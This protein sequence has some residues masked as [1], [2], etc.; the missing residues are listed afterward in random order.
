MC[1]PQSPAHLHEPKKSTLNIKTTNPISNVYAKQHFTLSSPN[2]T[3]NLPDGH[4]QPTTTPTH[5]SS[6]FGA[7]SLCHRNTSKHT[8][9]KPTCRLDKPHSKQQQPFV[10]AL[11]APPPRL[12]SFYNNRID[13]EE[14]LPSIEHEPVEGAN[15]DNNDIAAAAADGENLEWYIRLASHCYRDGFQWH[16]DYLRGKSAQL[17]AKQLTQRPLQ[18]IIERHIEHQQNKTNVKDALRG[19]QWSP[20]VAIDDSTLPVVLQAM[21]PT[22][23]ENTREYEI[24]IQISP[25]ENKHRLSRTNQAHKSTSSNPINPDKAITT[26][27]SECHK[28]VLDPIL[29]QSSTEQLIDDFTSALRISPSAQ[30]SIYDPNDV[31]HRKLPQIVLTDCC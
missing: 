29:L 5:L 3:N 28:Q 21:R 17:E 20:Q 9:K 2:D 16:A 10:A 18:L 19:D 15:D 6:S 4:P 25:Q 31:V 12:Y 27:S 8:S 23:P 24:R 11:D 30:T 1:T 7:K 14:P 22:S 13:A 26:S